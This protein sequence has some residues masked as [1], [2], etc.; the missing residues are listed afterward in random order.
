[1]RLKSRRNFTTGRA[2]AAS[3]LFGYLTKKPFGC[4]VMR[5][6]NKILQAVLNMI[7]NIPFPEKLFL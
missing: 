5:R 7:Q 1:V 6:H 4:G 3:R 2:F